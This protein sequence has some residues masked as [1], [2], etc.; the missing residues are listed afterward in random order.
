M[1]VWNVRNI[2]L[3]PLDT[4]PSAR[5]RPLQQL[6]A[7]STQHYRM[8]LPCTDWNHWNYDQFLVHSFLFYWKL[9]F[10]ALWTMATGI[11]GY[12][13]ASDTESDWRRR[14]GRYATTMSSGSYNYIA[15]VF[16]RNL[17]CFSSYIQ[18]IRFNMR[19]L[20]V[21]VDNGYLRLAPL[22]CYNRLQP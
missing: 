13:P 12:N 15:T 14:V 4:P 5:T 20:S 11:Y 7:T 16:A 9:H 22:A 19:T 21:Q 17:L 6:T 1:A 3:W 8:R 2:R 18:P 10:I